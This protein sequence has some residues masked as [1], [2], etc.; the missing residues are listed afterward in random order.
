MA[1]IAGINMPMK[2]HVWVGLQASSVSAVRARRR[3]ARRR[4][5]N[6]TT[7][8]KDLT[9]AEVER[10]RHEVAKFAVEGDLRREVGMKIKRLMD[11]GM[12]SRHA[13]SPRPAAARPA[14]AHQCTHPQGSAQGKQEVIRPDKAI[15]AKPA[16]PSRRRRSSA[17]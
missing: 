3:S 15:M 6:P 5:S 1:R 9:E 4:A 17:W 16:A 14:H 7:K 11:L 13:S 12:L 10:L 8:V 2:K